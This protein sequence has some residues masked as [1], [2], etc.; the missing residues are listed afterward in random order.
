MDV[1]EASSWMA[2]IV[3]VDT[4]AWYTHILCVQYVRLSDVHIIHGGL[5]W[6]RQRQR[7]VYRNRDSST[8]NS[9]QNKVDL[10]FRK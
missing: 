2:Y 8:K 9:R 10:N 7:G 1:E 3:E 6:Q 5:R 4:R